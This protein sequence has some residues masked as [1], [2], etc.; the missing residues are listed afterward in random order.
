ME[1]LDKQ[2]VLTY[3]SDMP[4]QFSA[5]EMLDRIITLSKIERGLEDVEQGRTTPHNEVIDKFRQWQQ[6]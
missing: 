3:L 1:L 5:E 4:D 6:R 2:K